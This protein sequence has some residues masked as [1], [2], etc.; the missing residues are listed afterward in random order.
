MSNTR[1]KQAF[2]ETLTAE[3]E[4]W[5]AL[6]DQISPAWML[7]PGASQSWTVKDTIA[8]TTWYEREMVDLLRK[9]VL[10]GSALWQMPTDERNQTIYRENRLRDL[11]EILAE[12]IQIY[13]ELLNELKKL[14]DEDL[15][16]PAR[17]DEMPADWLPW[18]VIASNTYEHYREH[19]PVIMGWLERF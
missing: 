5:D 3:R 9:R 16:D 13:Q 12:A 4:R 11:D 2:I 17:F 6:L 15:N 7:I 14:D 8:H 10:A 18:E 19:I 1:T